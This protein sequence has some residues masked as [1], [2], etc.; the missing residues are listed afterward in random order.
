M[1]WGRSQHIFLPMTEVMN[2]L[3]FFQWQK[4]ARSLHARCSRQKFKLQKNVKL[5]TEQLLLTLT[6]PY[7][8]FFSPRIFG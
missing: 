5:H 7:S 8:H 2:V 3:L 1:S 4:N 6:F